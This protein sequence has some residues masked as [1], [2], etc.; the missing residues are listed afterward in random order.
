M[1]PATRDVTVFNRRMPKAVRPLAR[2][3]RSDCIFGRVGIRSDSTIDRGE[4]ERRRQ[5]FRLDGKIEYDRCRRQN[6]HPSAGDGAGT[7]H[8]YVL[9][10]GTTI[11]WATGKL[12]RVHGN[13]CDHLTVVRFGLNRE[14]AK[15]CGHCHNEHDHRNPTSKLM[16]HGQRHRSRVGYAHIKYSGS[17]VR[18]QRS[19]SPFTDI[20]SNAP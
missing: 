6:A 11:M 10:D 3:R 16:P 20:G 9:V 13:A 17:P 7:V 1:R 2:S 5:N 12:I 19:S 18:R 14:H 8:I 15:A 4:F